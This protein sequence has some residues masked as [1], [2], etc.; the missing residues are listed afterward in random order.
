MLK[1]KKRKDR[2]HPFPTGE[3][4]GGQGESS[5]VMWGKKKH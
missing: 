5:D 4:R 3:I 2:K 1:K